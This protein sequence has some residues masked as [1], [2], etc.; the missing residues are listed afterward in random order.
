MFRALYY[1]Y[2]SFSEA[3]PEILVLWMNLSTIYE[4]QKLYTEAIM[5]LYEGLRV[6]IKVFT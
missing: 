1:A 3:Y 6:C 4:I 5:T 2:L